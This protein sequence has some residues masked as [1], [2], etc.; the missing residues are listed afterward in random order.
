MVDKSN[1]KKVV[2]NDVSCPSDIPELQLPGV[3]LEADDTKT[4]IMEAPYPATHFL[5]IDIEL[6]D[7]VGH[8]RQCMLSQN[9]YAKHVLKYFRGMSEGLKMRKTQTPCSDSV[10]LLGVA[11]GS[12]VLGNY[13]I[14]AR[15]PLPRP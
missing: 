7:P 13:K 6:R 9:K 3:V 15:T 1:D 10:A 5:G 11:E 14:H 12:E 2:D 8:K 4:L